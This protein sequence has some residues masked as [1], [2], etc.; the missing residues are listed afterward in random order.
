VRRRLRVGAFVV[1]GLGLAAALAFFVSP[2]ASGEPDGLNRVAIDEG[3]ADQEDNHALA[4]APTAGYAVEGV[5]DEGLSTGLAGL[6]GVA[7][8]FAVAGGLFL[9]VRRAGGTRRSPPPGTQ[10]TG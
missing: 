10:A 7:V 2:H 5:D 3:F 9:A 8:T 4:D 6:I 1:A